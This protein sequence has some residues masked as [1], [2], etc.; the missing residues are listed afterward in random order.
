MKKFNMLIWIFCIVL[1]RGHALDTD[2][3]QQFYRDDS[4]VQVIEPKS[5]TPSNVNTFYN[6]IAQD[7]ADPWVYKHTDGLYYFTRTTGGDVRI[8]RSR[9]FTSIDAGE[10]RIVWRSP[11]SGPACRAVWAPE[12]HFIQSSWYIYFAATTCDDKNENHRMFV[13]ENTNADPFTGTFTWK[14]QIT[15]VTNKWAIDGTVLQHPSGQL[16]FIWSGWQGDVNERQILYIAQM[17]NPWTISS[18]RVEIARPI[19]NWETNHF[20]YINEGPQ[21]TIR[22]GIISLVYSASGSWTNDYCLG[23]I[24]AFTNSDL[25]IASSWNK[26]PHPIFRSGNSIY[27]PGHQ[28]FTKSRD[29]REDWIIYH[30]ARYSGSGWTRQIRAQQFTWNMDSTPNLGSPVNPNIPIHIPSGDQNR[31]RYE[32]EHARH[33]NGPYAHPHSSASNGFKMGYIDY[34][35]SIVQF[36]IQCPKAGTYVIV[37]RNANGSAGNGHATH[38]LTINDVSQIEIPI[39]NSGWN[40]WGASMIRVNLNQGPNTLIFKKGL[41]FAEIDFIDVFLDE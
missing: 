21:V 16:Y 1:L 12:I 5:Q 41:N 8:W 22:N 19:Y 23:L 35:D 25:L 31:D 29:D 13:I 34:P 38:W 39:V 4:N 32:A 10:S 7:G 18:S 14:G 15:D 2:E 6:V 3:T 20:P 37:I 30:S 11:N 9:S 40:M 26:H 24:T 28:S 36:T 27:G 17:S 33:F